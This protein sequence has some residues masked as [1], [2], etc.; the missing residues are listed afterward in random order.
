[1]RAI[2]LAISLIAVRGDLVISI[3]DVL[4]TVAAPYLVRLLLFL[5][6]FSTYL[7]APRLT[8]NTTSPTN[9]TT[10]QAYNIDTGSLYN[11]M[12]FS[13]PKLR[14]LVSQLAPSIIRVGGTAVD[15]S[16]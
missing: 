2:S 4:N 1:M 5:F 11:G 10:K 14:T 9:P 7:R 16:L 3:G 15:Y 8:H 13:D 6:F 12:D